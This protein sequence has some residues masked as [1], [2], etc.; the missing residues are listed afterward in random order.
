[1]DYGGDDI[2]LALAW[3]LKRASWPYHD[4]DPENIFDYELLTHLK[5]QFCHFNEAEV[6]LQLY[7]V[8]VRRPHQHTL[9]Y[10]MKLYDEV[11]KAP[12]TL[13]FPGLAEFGDASAVSASIVSRDSESDPEDCFD[14]HFR[15]Q[16][17]RVSSRSQLLDC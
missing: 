6:A 4:C 3:L 10:R 9:H 15:Q 14:E 16:V 13:L 7:E 12:K 1:M 2:T 17:R 11:I 5:E 8:F